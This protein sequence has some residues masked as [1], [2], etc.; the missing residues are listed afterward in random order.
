MSALLEVRDLS[1][2]FV[3]RR[4]ALRTI[5]DISFSIDAGEV[6]GVVGESGAG[7]SLT[8]AAIIG[9]I[10][11]PGR[12]SGGQI[13]LEGQRIDNL[14]QA[15]M[16]TIRGRRIGAVFQDPLTSLNPLYTIGRQLV[17]T[18]RTHLDLSADAARGRAL[19]LLG[20]TGIPSP[21]ARFDHYP[22]QFSGG[23]RQRIVIAL[24]LAAGP[25]LLIADEPTTALDVS[26]Q[27][28]IIELLR[29]LCREHRTAVMLVT[30]DMGVIAE[31]AD[32]VAV[33]YA[34]RIVEIGRVADVIHRPQHPYTVGLMGSI[35]RFAAGLARL[36]QIDGAMPRPGAIPAGCAF[37]PRCPVAIER[38]RRERP[39]L[40][41]MVTGARAACWVAE[42]A[43]EAAR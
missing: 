39:D 15:A 43:T 27:A 20:S 14:S 16:R 19:E 8:G 9:L 10:E 38:C 29:R 36:A 28:Q 2:D 4:G 12:I 31:T 11:P 22:H 42:L 18:I 24:A 25:R 23:M 35:P 3:T 1:I 26:I 5:D 40:A 17:E 21:A 13:L 33:M 41:P 6:L 32:R 7:K 37:H 34:G 30:H